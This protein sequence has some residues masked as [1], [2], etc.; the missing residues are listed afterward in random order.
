M[1]TFLA[2]WIVLTIAGPAFMR[3]RGAQ[4]GQMVAT[5]LGILGT[6]L[7]IVYGL[8]NFNTADITNAVPQLLD[9]LKFAF[10]TSIA[11][12]T[13][14]LFI[15]A[16]PRK[17]GFETGVA[18]EDSMKSES[19]LLAEV[20][21]EMRQLNTNI[22][23]DND[24]TLIT[25]VQKLR[26]SIN[27]KQDELKQSFDEFAKQM[28][29]NNMKALIEAIQRVMDDF[30]TRIN[31]QLGQSF[32]ELKDSV[33]NL[34]Q[35]QQGYLETVKAAT[36]GLQAAQENLTASASSL[37]STAQKTAEIA[38][39]TKSIENSSTELRNVIE[40]LNT[41][42]DASVNFSQSMKDLSDNLESS[43]ENI[44]NEIQEIMN[45]SAKNV[46]E[47]NQKIMEDMEDSTR[48]TLSN[49]GQHMASI[50]EKLADDFQRVQAALSGRQN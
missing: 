33:V 25:Q 50:S 34:N 29:E 42:L 12:M 38:E 37:E 46:Q 27:D 8:I 41:L 16:F 36:E 7:G 48:T 1:Y 31:D 21:F 3:K 45:E 47:L 32:Q 11:G 2:V 20:L 10:V 18:A 15:G 14:S 22:A 40:N 5:T 24:T 43:G 23:G 28:A 13:V 17:L 26:T 49:F 4:E 44:R 35:W 19:E 6:F 30:N 39:N 9:G